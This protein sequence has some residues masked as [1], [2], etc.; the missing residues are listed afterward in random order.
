MTRTDDALALC[1]IG[2][3][4]RGLSVLERICANARGV[5]RPVEVHLVDPY[6]PGAGAV[7][8]T[9]QPGELLMNTVASQVTLFTDDSVDCAGPSVPGPSLYEWAC[10]IRGRDVE[11]GF[12][13]DVAQ[14]LP[15]RAV[16]EARRLGPDTYPTRAFHGHYL[17]WVFRHLLRTAPAH[18]T[19]R[20]HRT[21]AVALTDE[22]ETGH[23]EDTANP[24]QRVTLANGRRLAGL[25]AVVLALG[26]G[27]VTPSPEERALRAFADRHHLVHVA[28]ANPADTDLSRVAPGTPVALRGLGLNFFDCLA[29]LTEGRG[30]TFKEG[31]SGLVYLP[32][33]NEPVLYAGSRRGVPYHARGENEK[34]ALGRHEPRF[35]TPD[36]IAGLRRRVA[37]GRPLGFRRDLWPLVDRE[38]RTVHHE[39]RIRA[40]RG[41]E[42]AEEFVRSCLAD[43]DGRG[44][45]ALLDRHAVPPGERWDWERIER[46]YGER[47]FAGRADFRDWLLAYLRRDVAEARRGNV[48]GPLKAALDALRDLRNEIRLVV[49]HGGVSG[50]SYRAELDGWYTPLNAFTSIGPPAFRIEQLIA[51]I[52]AEVVQVLG[53]GMRVRA[54]TSGADAVAGTGE[55]GFLVDAESVDE[56]PVRVTALIE[57]RLPAVDL[58]RSTDPLLRGLLASGAC[59][60]YRLAGAPGHEPGGL[61]VT[62]GPP[63]LVDAAGR[64]HPRRFA[65]GVPVEG[66][67]WVTAVGIRPG[68]GSVTLEDSDAIARAALGLGPEPGSAPGPTAEAGSHETAVV[69]SPHRTSGTRSRGA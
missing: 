10:A 22:A 4:P 3:G 64:P 9:D 35:L 17:E 28:P 61:A 39:A 33:G 2:A 15:A 57:A 25:D 41:A 19:V 11:D 7:W 51:L 54:W 56:P 63:R 47:K 12:G 48:R 46:P 36:V 8:R 13:R 53:P 58:R 45:A 5:G 68:V 6:P 44:E 1:V 59:G 60:P 21:T 23:D 31:E 18:V 49:D 50:D 66:V 14:A 37:E 32:S 26:H 38:V 43:P 34:G 24:P 52:E 20:T 16:E 62:D 30:G 40:A 42:A 69:P 65:F 27:A 55:G 29:L 67:R